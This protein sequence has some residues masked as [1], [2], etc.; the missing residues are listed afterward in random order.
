MKSR[1][2][3]ILTILIIGFIAVQLEAG[4]K[5]AQ[6]GFQFLSVT[7]DAHTS[8]LGDAVTAREMGSASLFSNPAAL[9]KIDGTIEANFSMSKWIAEINHAVLS[10]AYKPFNGDYGVIGLSLQSVDYGDF[11]GTINANNDLGFIETGVFNPK[12]LAM[13][14]GYAKSITNQFSVGGHLKATY[15][16]LGNSIIVSNSDYKTKQNTV[17]AIAFDF[18][19]QFDTEFKRIVFGMTIRN[20]SDEIEYEVESFQLPLLFTIGAS[21]S[22]FEWIPINPV[23]QELLVSIDVSHPR[24]HPEQIKIGLD[25]TLMNILSLRSGFISNND[26]DAFSFGAGIQY[27]GFHFDYAYSPFGVFDKVQRITAKISL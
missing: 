27:S 16:N 25:Y 3:N 4:N 21:T 7:S 12:A 11:L 13:G 20:F 8:S 10:I 1:I 18:G 5:I 19:T 23:D 24:S 26:E 22:L 9:A 15:Q 2:L 6:T 14:I 17:S